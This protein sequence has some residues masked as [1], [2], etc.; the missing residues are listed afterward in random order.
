MVAVVRNLI[1]RLT[2]VRMRHL[3]L[4][5]A[6]PR[7]VDRVMELLRQR[8]HQAELLKR[9]S[10]VWREKGSAAQADRGVW[11]PDCCCCRREAGSYRGRSKRI[12]L[13]DITVAQ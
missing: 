4:I 11:S 13:G 12:S 3:F 5:L 6:S 1:G 7:Y 2:D 8:L 10:K 9:K